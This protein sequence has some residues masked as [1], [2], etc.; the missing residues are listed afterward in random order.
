M[1]SG[2]LSALLIEWRGIIGSKYICLILLVCLNTHIS[3]IIRADATKL[4]GYM[5]NYCTQIKLV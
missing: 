1:Y 2:F 3:A 5:S 4:V